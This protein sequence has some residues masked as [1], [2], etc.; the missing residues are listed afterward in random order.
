LL[1]CLADYMTEQSQQVRC[2][3]QLARFHPT[4]LARPRATVS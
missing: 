4:D 3:W 2:R 1:Y